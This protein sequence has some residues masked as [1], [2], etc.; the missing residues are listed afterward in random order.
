MYLKIEAPQRCISREAVKVWRMTE[1]L[2]NT[3]IIAVLL[4][5][6]YLHI[7]FEWKEW[8]GWI[9][10]GLIVLT[11]FTA[12]WEI[13]FKP[14]FMQKYWRYDVNEEFIQLKYGAFK[15]VNELV[16]MTKVQ[17][18]ELIQ[19]PLMRKYN[20]YSIQIGTMGTEHVIPAISEEEAFELRDQIAHYAKIK[21]V[22]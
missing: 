6:Y 21:E 1:T 17:S 7:H 3:G 16:P 18:V 19:G 4:V 2:T 14:S 8:I 10:L 13:L 20:L 22:E 9:V 5:L 15:E 11:F 12:I